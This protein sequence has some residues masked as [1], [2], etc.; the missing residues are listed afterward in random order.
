VR[1]TCRVFLAC[2]LAIWLA[3]STRAQ[4][5]PKPGPEHE[6]LKQFEGKWD[7]TVKAGPMESKG[8]MTYKM[9]LGGLWLFSHFE[10]DFGGTKFEGRGMDTYDPIKK[11]HAVSGFQNDGA[12]WTTTF[13]FDKPSA[14]RIPPFWT[15][16][17]SFI[18]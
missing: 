8:T 7:A 4:E 9:G 10:G 6:H 13:T 16:R 2:A 11:I 12:T 3:P 15:Y 1:L 18:W 17:P 14:V 5:L